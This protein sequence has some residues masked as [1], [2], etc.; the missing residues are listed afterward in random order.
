M[1]LAL[2][3]QALGLVNRI[4]PLFVGTLDKA[5][6]RHHDFFAEGGLPK[7]ADVAVAEVRLLARLEMVVSPPIQAPQPPF[8]RLAWPAQVRIFKRV[9]TTR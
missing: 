9:W 2:E 5:S 4:F 1:R 3:L 8:R 6:N 7:C